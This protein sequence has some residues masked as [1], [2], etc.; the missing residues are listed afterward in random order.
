MG[1]AEAALLDIL[2]SIREAAPEWKL[3][4]IVSEDGPLVTKAKQLGVSTRVLPFPPSLTR[5]G[6]SSAGG[7][8]GNSNGRWTLYRQLFFA[9]NGVR[10]YAA[11][12]RKILREL[13]PDLIHTNGFKMHILGAT[14]KP[15]GVPLVWHVHD[16]VQPRPLMAK[17]MKLFQRRCKVALANSNRVALD[18]R[19]AC[20]KSLPVQTIYNGIDTNVFS[21]RGDRLDL[22]TLSGLP[23]APADIVRVGMVATFARW[24][25]QEVFLQALSLVPPEL[26]WRGYIVGGA[27]YQTE[28]SQYSLTELKAV[29]QQLGISD[30]VGFSGLVDQPAA[31]M[32]SLDVVVHASTV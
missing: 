9:G 30:R 14:A 19:A 12:L 11:S 2:G 6:D 20:G 13:A 29:A 18:I 1:G 10:A 7:P 3:D 23:P 16:F 22:D 24:K 31:A 28:G 17:L 15:K 32:R 8:A 26:P 4:L 5:L 21:P 25:G 27:L